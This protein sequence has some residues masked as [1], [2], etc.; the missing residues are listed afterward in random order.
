MFSFIVSF[1]LF[2]A[3]KFVRSSDLF[4]HIL[5]SVIFFFEFDLYRRRHMHETCGTGITK[6]SATTTTVPVGPWRL[7][8]ACK[9]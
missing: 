3:E 5:S 7:I 8:C 1:S 9:S 2:L 6:L 4:H